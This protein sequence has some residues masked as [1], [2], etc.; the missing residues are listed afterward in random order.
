MKTAVR[1]PL[2]RVTQVQSVHEAIQGADGLVI[3]TD[4]DE[5]RTLDWGQVKAAMNGTLVFDG[6]NCLDRHA[7]EQSGLRYMGVGRP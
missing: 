4:W 5:F 6:R 2:T 1:L 7:V 3:A